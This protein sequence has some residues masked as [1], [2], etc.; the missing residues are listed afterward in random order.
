MELSSQVTN[1][2]YFNN[3]IVVV[4]ST[5]I[6]YLNTVCIVPIPALF[7][8]DCGVC[9]YLWQGWLPSDSET[10]EETTGSGGVRWQAERRAAMMTT[11]SYAKA[12]YSS[13]PPLKLVWAGHEPR[14]FINFFPEWEVN[15]TVA[16]S[17]EEVSKYSNFAL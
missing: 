17:N 1:S 9:L 16:R 15:S 7:L 12:K 2:N 8:A 5:W 11:L 3:C 13:I 4:E 14:E 10:G 6:E